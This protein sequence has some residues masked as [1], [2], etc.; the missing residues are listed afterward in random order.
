MA[1]SALY[2]AVT[3]VL[4]AVEGNRRFCVGCQKSRP[5]DG[6]R[7]FRTKRGAVVRC[8]ECA[9]RREGPKGARP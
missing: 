4:I 5:A 6:F 8:G 9:A 7:K 3:R 2:D 1:T